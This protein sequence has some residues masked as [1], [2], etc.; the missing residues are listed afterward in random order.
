MNMEI[1]YADV[2]ELGECVK[3]IRDSFMT[4]ANELGYTKENAPGLIPFSVSEE[5][6]KSR[7]AEGRKM[8]SP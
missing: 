2:H 8:E 1:R 3:V 5:K 7:F 6:R 4:V